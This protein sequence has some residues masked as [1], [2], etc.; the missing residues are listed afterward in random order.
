MFS[1]SLVNLSF[2]AE[3]PPPDEIDPFGDVLEFFD[4]P[5][6][7][8]MLLSELECRRDILYPKR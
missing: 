4:D 5:P 2:S 8:R 1:R 7:W 6:A 3:F